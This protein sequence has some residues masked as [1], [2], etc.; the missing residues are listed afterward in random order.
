MISVKKSC[1]LGL[2][3]SLGGV[4]LFNLGFEWLHQIGGRFDR[5]NGAQSGN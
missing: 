5:R 4:L 2:A 3:L 1:L